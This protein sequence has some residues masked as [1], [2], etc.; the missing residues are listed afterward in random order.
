MRR[1]VLLIPTCGL[2]FVC[3]VTAVSQDTETTTNTNKAIRVT[4][5]LNHITVLE[6]QEPVTLVAA[7]CPDFQ[8]ERQENKVF[9][10]PLQ[11]G[12]ATNLFVWTASRRFNYALESSVEVKTMNFVI[13]IYDTS[14]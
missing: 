11:S 2:C 14:H 6:F 12:V 3:A 4:T 13:D 10:K 8:I 5:A 7:G 1:Q 9:V